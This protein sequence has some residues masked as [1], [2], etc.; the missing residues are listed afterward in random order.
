MDS[1]LPGRD[2]VLVGAGH[3]NAHVL[4]M[5]MRP[6]PD[7]RLTVVSPFPVATYSGMLPGTLAGLYE[8]DEMTIDLRRLCASRGARL[9]V[10]PATGLDPIAKRIHLEDRPSIPYDVAAIGIG[11]VP[12][13]GTVWRKHPNVLAI[14]PMQTFRDRLDERMFEV[15]SRIEG[16]PVRVAV[17]GAG[18]AGTEVALC[19]WARFRREKFDTEVVLLDGGDSIL[20]GY[21][22]GVVRRIERVLDE[23]DIERRLGERV[24]GYDA[25]ELITENGTRITAD[26]VVWAAGAAPPRMLDGFDLP[27]SEDGFLAVD[28]T[29]RTTAGH[30]VFVAGDTATLV[31]EPVPKAGVYAVREGPVLLENL[32]RTFAGKPLREY[33]PQSGFLSL[34]ALGDGRAVGQYMGWAFGG[35]LAWWLKNRI[36]QRFMEMHRDYRPMPMKGPVP[37]GAEANEAMRCRGCGGKVG[38]SVLDESLERLGLGSPG[39]EDAAVL[40]SPAEL[41]TIDVFQ[42]FADDPYLVGRIAALNAMS[43]LWATGGRPT[44]ALATVTLPEGRRSQQV[45]L[46]YQMLAGAIRE[47]ERCG[48]TLAGGHT[49][50]GGEWSI[51]F[52]VMGTLDGQPALMNDGLCP[53]N[54]LVLTKPLGTGALLAA[55]MRAACRAEWHES[56]VATMLVPN[57]A[58]AEIARRYGVVAATDVTGFGLAGHLFEI[59]DASGV[60]ATLEQSS[61]PR[62]PGFDEAVT[63]GYRSSLEPSNR[64]IADRI[65]GPRAQPAFDALFDP[66]TSGGLLLAVPEERVDGLLEELGTQSNGGPTA[67]RIGRVTECAQESRLDLR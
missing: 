11:S 21:T 20:S 53:G 64:E 18:A 16:R 7:V 34:L 8:P 3:T 15:R 44:S 43:D 48:V 13:G 60:S 65:D 23:R 4:R 26:V 59:L 10:A 63:A 40:A 51:G 52:V 38:A 24:Q 9:I 61:L 32:R 33:R 46:L 39:R 49:R 2:L 42:A 17:V 14:K 5:W 62:L 27:R 25:G 66:Q 19:L 55:A 58:A 22:D 50:E 1:P 30:D 35:R 67:V 31:D 6:I 45:E 36:D 47:F 28:R 57:D 37:E 12:A 54:V 29:L 56:M 41:V